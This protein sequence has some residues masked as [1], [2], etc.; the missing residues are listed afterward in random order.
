M[1]EQGDLVAGYTQTRQERL[2]LRDIIRLFQCFIENMKDGSIGNGERIDVRE[3]S[4]KIVTLLLQ[5]YENSPECLKEPLI[6]Q[7][8]ATIVEKLKVRHLVQSVAIHFV[9]YYILIIYY[10][11]F[12]IHH[13]SFIIQSSYGIGLRPTNH[14]IHS[15]LSLP[16]YSSHRNW[17]PFTLP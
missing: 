3:V 5:D 16:L 12:I 15:R 2:L 13:S 8:A 7:F 14:S 11:S 17:K 10:P 9:S 6:L 1:K 4:E